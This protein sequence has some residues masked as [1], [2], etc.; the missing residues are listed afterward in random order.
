VTID[1]RD[2]LLLAVVRDVKRWVITRFRERSQLEVRLLGHAQSL[3]LSLASWPDIGYFIIGFTVDGLAMVLRH[4]IPRRFTGHS[5]RV[6]R[7]G[8]T[9]SPVKY[10][11]TSSNPEDAPGPNYY[12]LTA[13]YK[14]LQAQICDPCQ[15]TCG[16]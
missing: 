12:S 6:S 14:C 7:L 16:Q 9:M 4:R 2:V 5:S 10:R 1:Y 3:P 11:L 8:S 13:L 15:H